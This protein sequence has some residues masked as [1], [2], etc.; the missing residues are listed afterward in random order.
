[1]AADDRADLFGALDGEAVSRVL[2]RL[3]AEEA[4]DVA[5]LSNYEDE[6]AGGIMTSE[7]C[8]LTPSMTAR[9]AVERVREQATNR[10]TIYALY[11]LDD[12]G[13]LLG[14]V[15]L[16]KLILCPPETTVGEIMY[17][18]PIS[19]AVDADQETVMQR[20]SHYDFLAIPVVD[21]DG[22]MVGIVTHDDALDVALEE[23]D[24]DAQKMGG[25]EPLEAPYFETAIVTLIRKRATWL[26]VLL[27]AGLMAGTI[28]RG[29]E[30]IL[31]RAM[32]LIFF[33]PLIIASGGNSGSQSATL[34]IRGLAVGEMRLSDW[35]R[36]AQRELVSGLALGVLLGLFGVG[37]A[38]VWGQP[39]V[40]H[41]VFLTLVAIV[42]VGSLLGSLLPLGLMRV[43]VDP[44][45][46]SS[47]LVAG[48]VDIL[49]VLIYVLVALAILPFPPESPRQLVAT[50]DTPQTVEL[51]WQDVAEEQGYEVE[52]RSGGGEFVRI[53]ALG[54]D[55]VRFVDSG[56]A[57]GV[58][59]EY[60]VRATS[61][62]GPS[63]YSSIGATRSR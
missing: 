63:R 27:F 35:W 22:K 31:E 2:G 1:M 53:A 62:N 16:T 21:G 45:I 13:R 51:S 48:L 11:V 47:P 42:T 4:K 40:S 12:E 54:A 39:A 56:L 43:G 23:A 19:C 29:F 24:E 50:S 26:T 44:A 25:V 10:E 5:V 58:L 33:L 17:D 60:R 52:R 20:L 36:I 8:R 38:V 30:V 7:F 3:P 15:S 9:E 6:T 59:Y 46:T 18:H 34:V 49:G 57:A 41:T 14:V 37:I 55:E 28:L 32:A 61:P